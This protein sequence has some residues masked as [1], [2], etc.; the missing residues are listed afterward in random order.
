MMMSMVKDVLSQGHFGS[1]QASALVLFVSLLTI[2]TVW[3]YL[4]GA[5]AYYDR[6]ATDLLKGDEHG[7]TR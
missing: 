1:L 7:R 3:I 6:V 4:P 2:I 5:K